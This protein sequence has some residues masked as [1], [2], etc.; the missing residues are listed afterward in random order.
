M[1][2]LN[3][4]RFVDELS[5]LLIKLQ[6][7]KSASSAAK[8]A[9]VQQEIDD[10]VSNEKANGYLIDPGGLQ[11]DVAHNLIHNYSSVLPAMLGLE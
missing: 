3:N 9:A 10:L 8:A 4:P 2:G 5:Q 7:A 11:T 1:T 6:T